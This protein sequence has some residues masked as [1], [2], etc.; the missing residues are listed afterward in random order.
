M[1]VGVGVMKDYNLT[2]RNLRVSHT[3]TSFTEQT[4]PPVEATRWRPSTELRKK[5][6]EKEKTV[7][8]D[9]DRDSDALYKG[10]KFRLQQ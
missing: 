6:K 2:L 9:R 3:L 1:Y 4:L 10:K 8:G 5:E 7:V